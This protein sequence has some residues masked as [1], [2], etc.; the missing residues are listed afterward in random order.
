[1][2]LFL[3]LM[4]QAAFAN[5]Y[6]DE[7][8]VPKDA[9]YPP[10]ISL[11]VL[12]APKVSRNRVEAGLEVVR[13]AVQVDL[14]K[15]SF[16]ISRLVKE[17]SGTLSTLKRAPRSSRYGSYHALLRDPKT[18]LVLAYDSIGT[19]Q[20]Y[21]KL[22]DEIT[23]RFPL[24][25]A[26][27]KF[28]LTVENPVTGKRELVLTQTI[29]PYAAV[30]APVD[31][32]GLEIRELARPS[33]SG[34]WLRVNIYSEG[35]LADRESVFWNDAE[36][37]AAALLSNQFPGVEHM[38]FYGV[39]HPSKERLGNAEDFGAERKSRDTFLGLYF[40][41]WEKF[42]RWYNVVYPAQEEKFR[43]GLAVAP[44]DYAIVVT[45]D[46]AYWGIG[47]FRVMT[48]VP[49]HHPSFIYLLLHEA[50]HFFGLNEEYEENGSTELEFAPGIEEPWSPNI[51][52]LRDP[53]SALLK[54]QKF[55]APE[56]RLPTPAKDWQNSPPRY[57]AYLGGYA[58]SAPRNHSHKPGFDC[59]MER[60]TNFCD[61]CREAIDEIVN[62][63]RGEQGAG[64]SW[65]KH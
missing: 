25:S 29:N 50:G 63:D 15:E 54:W 62:F 22:I 5:P 44:Y 8:K 31:G 39:F 21:R 13:I 42:G 46:S 6:F 64:K 24:P 43:A 10:P 12:S 48:T 56:T 52:F 61:I 27:V 3:L 28:E 1:M 32:S 53:E 9:A 57:G 11:P 26:S 17:N 36:K 19:G 34:D 23:F 49:A 60:G 65:E 55:V 4:T 37:T 33:A 47:N 40:P 58:G 30:A 35:Y 14:A 18:S 59:V 38:H 45:D 2:K 51:T 20:E 7:T 41:Y 16:S